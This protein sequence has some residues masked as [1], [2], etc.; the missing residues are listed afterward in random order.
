MTVNHDVVVPSDLYH[1]SGE[2][3]ERKEGVGSE[4]IQNGHDHIDSDDEMTVHYDENTCMKPEDYV[5][6]RTFVYSD[7]DK[8]YKECTESSTEWRLELVD[9]QYDH[10]NDKT[11]YLYEV[12]TSHFK[13]FNHCKV[14]E[15]ADDEELSQN[16]KSIAI[17]M[18]CDCEICIGYG[19]HE[20]Q[21]QGT[22]AQVLFYF[23]K[24]ISFFIGNIGVFLLNFSWK[25]HG[26]G[27][28]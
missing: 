3:S 11:E 19:V 15:S 12:C 24:F 23:F 4:G 26:Y 28:I 10:H 1:R 13:P 16:L 22:F 9:W 25:K 8:I 27:R 17:Q 20:M 7:Y 18:P 21:P 2:S 6:L 14:N 5:P